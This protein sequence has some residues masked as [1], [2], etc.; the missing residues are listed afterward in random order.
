MRKGLIAHGMGKSFL[1]L[2]LYKGHGKNQ[3]R[4]L[5]SS[6]VESGVT[7][8]SALSFYLRSSKV[9]SGLSKER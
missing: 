7:P 3:M 2:V 6:D 5:A 9:D 1:A 8:Q 4:M